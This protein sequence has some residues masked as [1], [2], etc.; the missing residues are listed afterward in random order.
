[1]TVWDCLCEAFEKKILT[2]TAIVSLFEKKAS[3]ERLKTDAR[4]ELG[5]RK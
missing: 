3:D 1:M 5:H 4:A 2:K